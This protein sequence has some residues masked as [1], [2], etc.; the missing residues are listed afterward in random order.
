MVGIL[1]LTSNIYLC[2]I[3]GIKIFAGIPDAWTHMVR[4]ID[5][6]MKAIMA[7]GK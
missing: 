5:S 2:V 7:C 4:L 3:E 1:E 6:G